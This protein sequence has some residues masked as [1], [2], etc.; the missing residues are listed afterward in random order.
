VEALKT[1][2]APA[3]QAIPIFMAHGSLDS[4]VAMPTGQAAFAALKEMQY[5]IEWHQYPMDHAVCLEEIRDIAAFI[6]GV[7]K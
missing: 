7:F 6:N 3:N 1:E 4:V 5:L 2:A